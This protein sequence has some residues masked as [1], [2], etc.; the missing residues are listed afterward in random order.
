MSLSE[1]L[2]HLHMGIE[3]KRAEFDE[4]ISRLKTAKSNIRTEQDLAQSDIKEIKKP[5]LDSSWKGERGTDFHRHRKEAYHVMHDIVNNEYETY[6][7]EIDQKIMHFELKKM[8]LAVASN[9]AGR[10]QDVMEKGEDFAK[11]VK[12]LIERGWKAL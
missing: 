5:A 9:F 11:D 6:I 1:M 3:N 8:E 4:M 12:H 7:T 10:A 2:H